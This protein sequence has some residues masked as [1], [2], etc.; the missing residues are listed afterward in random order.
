[1]KPQRYP[2]SL[3][4]LHW[5]MAAMILGMIAGGYIMKE[6]SGKYPLRAELYALHKSFGVVVLALIALRIIVRILSHVPP[7]PQGLGAMEKKGAKAGHLL[8]YAGMVTVPLSGFVMSMAGGHGIKLFGW[9]LPNPL[10]LN[11]KLSH[12]AHEWHEQLPYVLLGVIALHLAGA[13]KHR[14]ADDAANDV[15]PRM[16]IR[17]KRPR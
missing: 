15:L 8:L 14:F 12:F 6:L 5:L 1:M 10:E 17:P 4:I 3:R 2:T 13:L 11:R 16:G 9:E 7:L